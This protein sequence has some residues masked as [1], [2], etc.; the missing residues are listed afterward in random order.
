MSAST[1]L[2]IVKAHFLHPTC[3]M[4]QVHDLCICMCLQ[5]CV[6]PGQFIKLNNLHAAIYKG[7]EVATNDSAAFPT[8]ELTIHHGT[9]Y[10]RGVAFLNDDSPHVKTVKQRMESCFSGQ[11]CQLQLL[12]VMVDV[13]DSVVWCRCVRSCLV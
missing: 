7:E 2:V 5:H 9:A 4:L 11:S 12:L 1:E 10:G 6:Q 13:V 8:L 3:T